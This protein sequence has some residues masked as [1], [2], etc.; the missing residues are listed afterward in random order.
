[1]HIADQY[2][3]LPFAEHGRD[4]AGLDCWGLVRLFLAEQ[5]GIVM[6]RYDRTDDV[7]TVLA[8][9]K[10][11]FAVVPVGDAAC[12]DVLICNEHVRR[13]ERWAKAPVHVAVCVAPGLALHITKGATSRVDQIDGLDV[14]EVRRVTA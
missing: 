11:D 6:P 4:R 13:N 14:V 12:F 8:H 9:E 2:V 10:R 3:G 5:A 7:E 1:M